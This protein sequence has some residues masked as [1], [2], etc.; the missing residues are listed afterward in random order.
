MLSNGHQYQ[1]Q[2]SVSSQSSSIIS[3]IPASQ[4]LLEETLA[5]PGPYQMIVLPVN[6]GYWIDGTDHECAFDSRGNPVLPL[7]AWRGK[8][9]TDD[10][11]KCYRRFFIG[12]VSLIFFKSF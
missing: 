7:S 6:G 12:R 9:E 8:F 4:R 11:A 2:S 10:T 5:K 3:T 1:S